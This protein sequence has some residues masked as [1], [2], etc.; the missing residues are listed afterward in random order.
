MQTGPVIFQQQPAMVSTVVAPPHR[1]V[2]VKETRVLGILQ[3]VIGVITCI[4]GIASVAALNYWAG[5]VG[6]GI[7]GGIWIGVGGIIGV[8]SAAHP[9]NTCLNGTNMAFAIVSSIIAFIEFIIYC[10]AVSFYRNYRSCYYSGY[11][12]YSYSCNSSSSATGTAL[13][14]ILLIAMI[15]EFAISLAVAIYCCKHGCGCCD[16]STGGVIV[17]GQPQ[18]TYIQSSGVAYSNQP[19]FVTVPASTGYVSAYPNQQMM[20]QQVTYTTNAPASAYPM[21][22]NTTPMTYGQRFN[23]PTD[24]TK[25][26]FGEAPPAYSQP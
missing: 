7:W 13:Y 14:A 17:Q 18:T 10:V 19:T 20:Q 15:A 4:F 12:Y 5:H 24:A 2:P 1:T 6:F 22:T 25:E 16:N 11:P 3:I 8:C 21:A 26:S 23:V 9:T